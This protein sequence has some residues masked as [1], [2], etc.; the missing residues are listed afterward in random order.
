[1]CPSARVPLATAILVQALAGTAF[2]ADVAFFGLSPSHPVVLQ[3]AVQ[4]LQAN[5][6]FSDNT[7]ARL[8]SSALAAGGNHSCAVIANGEVRC[9]G[10]NASGQ[11]GNVANTGDSAQPLTATL[12]G[13]ATAVAV[14]GESSCA[15]QTD[16]VTKCWGRNAEGQLGNGTTTASTAPVTATGVTAT[17]LAGGFHHM[18]ALLVGGGV[19]CWGANNAGQLGNGTTTGATTAVNVTGISTAVAIAAGGNHSCAVLASGGVKCWGDDAAGQLG[20]GAAGASTTPV[21]V[22]GISTAIGIAT[23]FD[24]SCALLADGTVRCWGRGLEG[25]L[26]NGSQTNSATPV[27][28]I[29]MQLPVVALG[30]GASHTCAV[31]QSGIATCW[32]RN[33]NGQIGNG[34]VVGN[35][36]LPAAV[37]GLTGAIAISGGFEHTCALLVEGDV[38]CW[39]LNDGGQLGMGTI[40]GAVQRSGTPLTVNGPTS[41]INAGGNH[42]CATTPSGTVSCWG[43]GFYGQL[44]NNATL[45]SSLPVKV[46]NTDQ[47]GGAAVNVTN[48]GLGF[49]H[50]CGVYADGDAKCWGRNN[51]VQLGA[52]IISTDLPQAE[53]PTDVYRMSSAMAI[54]SGSAHSCVVLFTGEVQCWGNNNFRQTGYDQPALPSFPVTVPGIT[55]ALNVSAGFE[56]T[57]AVLTS[58]IVQCWGRGDQGQLGNGST[59]NSA[60]P[61]TVTGITTATAV[62]LGDFHSCARL[63]GGALRCWGRNSEGQL[64]NGTTTQSS[65][66]VVVSGITTGSVVAAG[67]YHTCARLSTGEGRC[68]GRGDAGQLGNGFFVNISSPVVVTGLAGAVNMDAGQS[69]TCAGLVG[70]RIQCWGYNQFGQLGSGPA[71]AGV[72]SATPVNV[73]GI[74]IDAAGLSYSSDDP[75]VAIVDNAGTVRA[76]G[77]GD[78]LIRARY[79]SKQTATTFTVAMDTDGDTVPDPIDNCPLVPNPTQCDSDNDG[80]GNHCDGDLNNNGFT[81]AQDTTLFRAQL[82]LPSNPPLYNQADLNCNGFV[83]SQDTTL[84]RQR[85]GKPSG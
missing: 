23:G 61:V 56:H 85:L 70:A 39:G 34:Q 18:C 16:G 19:S 57:C 28:A 52:S 25:Q 67:G 2:A 12:F 20:N 83:N 42:T 78:T 27:S 37:T 72:N 6:N 4:R 43:S 54:A 31:S 1:M 35:V 62:S 48:V 13:T 58:G 5:G 11:L 59:A 68:W 36:P 45:D 22:T 75:S 21:D 73:N 76:V 29:G 81:N 38:K 17:T 40:G 41:A 66:P 74:N 30:A 63:V 7:N 53:T 24:H 84:F 55:T 32:G 14:G 46:V 64:G 3:G 51:L 69:H 15:L 44:G 47:A 71:S 80:F 79:D 10:R 49:E 77:L 33:A 8:T 82:G 9:W 50:T 26:G 60:A 65:V